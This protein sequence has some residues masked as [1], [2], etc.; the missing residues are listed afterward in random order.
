MKWFC[1]YQNIVE[2][3]IFAY[4]IF[5]KEQICSYKDALGVLAIRL[6]CKLITLYFH[7]YWSTY[8]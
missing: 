6:V 4:A 8:T 1:L 7:F 2:N 3:T 5:D